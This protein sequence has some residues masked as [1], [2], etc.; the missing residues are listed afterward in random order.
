MYCGISCR[1]VAATKNY[2]S[3]AYENSTHLYLSVIVQRFKL[4]Y[5]SLLP[6]FHSRSLPLSSLLFDGRTHYI[7]KHTIETIFVSRNTSQTINHI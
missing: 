7:H 4:I 3:S 6:L 1:A 5:S 2:T